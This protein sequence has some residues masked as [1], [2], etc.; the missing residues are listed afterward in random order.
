MQL[1]QTERSLEVT[2][3]EYTNRLKE[4]ERRYDEKQD[5]Y[6]RLQHEEEKLDA[7]IKKLEGK[8]NSILS[9]NQQTESTLRALE[10]EERQ[11][12][13]T[14]ETNVSQGDFLDVS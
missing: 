11:L 4:A 7:E 8:I 9:A 3:E 1:K 2:R 12:R 6:N 10:C 13:K 5:D 14:L